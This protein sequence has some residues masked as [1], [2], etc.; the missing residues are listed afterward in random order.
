MLALA[1]LVLQSVVTSAVYAVNEDEETVPEMTV[2]TV[3]S[4]PVSDESN[5]N[6]VV[7]NLTN[8][9]VTTSTEVGEIATVVGSEEKTEETIIEPE[10]SMFEDIDFQPL[11][12]RLNLIHTLSETYETI[13]TKFDEFVEKWN[14]AKDCITNPGLWCVNNAKKWKI[15]D[16]VNLNPET[17]L[18][19]WEVWM[20]KLVQPGEKSWEYDVSIAI[21]SAR[22]KVT[23]TWDAK[24]CAVVVF[25]KSGSMGDWTKWRNAKNGAIAF[26]TNLNDANTNSYIWLVTFSTTASQS[27]TL[28]HKALSDWDFW[29]ANW[30]TN[31]HAWLIEA[32]NMLTNDMCNDASKYIVVI[33]DGEPS[34]FVNWEYEHYGCWNSD[35]SCTNLR[36]WWNSWNESLCNYYH[37]AE[38]PKPS[39]VAI[40]YAKWI[41]KDIE[42]FSIWYETD[43]TA[44]DILSSV[45]SDWEWQHFF[46]GDASNVASAFNNIATTVNEAVAWHNGILVDGIG[47]PDS[48]SF[49]DWREWS[50]YVETIDEIDWENMVYTF[51]VKIDEQISMHD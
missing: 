46:P 19:P 33:S 22:A 20:W 45:A 32:N 49:V 30:W 18:Q 15:W 24:V 41:Q 37:C 44:N 31:L 39:D 6:G 35:K 27:R 23:T 25:D 28:Q 4:D 14:N 21:K 34:F 9:E 42:I 12:L 47:M 43:D 7:T 2:G 40:Q 1:V 13:P 50:T 36:N 11:K 17:E 51:T 29:S 8:S 16:N 10:S 5:N 38:W 26:S 3:V 48:L